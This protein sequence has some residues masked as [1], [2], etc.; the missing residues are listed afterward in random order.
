MPVRLDADGRRSIYTE[1]EVPG[2]PEEVWRAV[3]TGPG[4]SSWF[5]PSEVEERVGGRTV[6]HFG[7]GMDGEGI[8]TSWEPPHLCS[9]NGGE[10]GNPQ[11]PIHNAEWT[12][13]PLTG[14]GCTV[15]VVHRW[16]GDTTDWDDYFESV[17][18][19][20]HGFFRI[21]RLYLT[22]FRD[23]NCTPVQLV[24]MAGGQ[25]STV[26]DVLTGPLGFA[27]AV[28][29]QQVRSNPGSP[30]LGGIVEEVGSPRAP[31]DLLVRL[32]DPSPGI[33]H[34][35]AYQMGEDAVYLAANLYLYGDKAAETAAILEPQMQAWIAERFPAPEPESP[36]A[37]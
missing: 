7:P 2:T 5:V 28:A 3:A 25:S 20:W 15:R 36:T 24:A 31:E 37:V 1:V 10:E 8:I 29:G 4:I 33:A 6:A 19:G 17:D 22:H 11:A 27:G 14:G 30:S 26:W 16:A 35:A 9:R 21:L 13:K 34:L 23:Q 18:K 12:V 32:N